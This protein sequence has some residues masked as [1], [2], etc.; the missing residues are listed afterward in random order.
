MAPLARPSTGIWMLCAGAVGAT[1][2]LFLVWRDSASTSVDAPTGSTREVESIRLA[3]ASSDAGMPPVGGRSAISVP[4]AQVSAGRDPLDSSASSDRRVPIRGRFVDAHG[5]VVAGVRIHDPSR[6]PLGAPLASSGADGEFSLSLESPIPSRLR[7]RDARLAPLELDPLPEPDPTG[8]IDLGDLRLEEGLALSVSVVDAAGAPIAAAE[9]QRVTEPAGIGEIVGPPSRRGEPWARTDALGRAQLDAL[10]RGPVL[11][12]VR[13]PD[14]TPTLFEGQ[15]NG[16]PWERSAVL[17]LDHRV[18]L[19][20]RIDGLP[21]EKA[22]NCVVRAWPTARISGDA[23]DTFLSPRPIPEAAATSP[24]AQGSFQFEGLP[25][26]GTAAYTVRGYSSTEPTLPLTDA[27]QSGHDGE[28]LVLR[29]LPTFELEIEVQDRASGRRIPTATVEVR[30]EWGRGSSSSLPRAAPGGLTRVEIPAV[31]DSARLTIW[32]RAPGYARSEAVRPTLARPGAQIVSLVPAAHLLVQVVEAGSLRPIAAAEV[33]GSFEGSPVLHARGLVETT[34]TTDIDGLARLSLDEPLRGK[35]RVLHPDHAPAGPIDVDFRDG[36][37]TEAV[38]IELSAGGQL[39]IRVQP[40]SGEAAAAADIWLRS[41]NPSADPSRRSGPRDLRRLRTDDDGHL[42]LD[43]L[44]PGEYRLSVAALPTP[45]DESEWTA[46]TVRAG[47]RSAC[48][49]AA[50]GRGCIEALIVL[51]QDVLRGATVSLWRAQDEDLEWTRNRSAMRRDGFVAETDHQGIQRFCGRPFG[52]YILEAWH[53]DLGAP[54]RR[55][56]DLRSANER[57]EWRIASARIE[58]RVVAPD[59]GSGVLAVVGIVPVDQLPFLLEQRLSMHERGRPLDAS[60]QAGLWRPALTQTDGTFALRIPAVGG[61]VLVGQSPEGLAFTALGELH[62]G[63]TPESRVVRLA[64]PAVLRIRTT[65]SE[66]ALGQLDLRV[67]GEVCG[68]W[69]GRSLRIELPKGAASCSLPHGDWSLSVT[70][71]VAFERS[72]LPA[73]LANTDLAK[74][75]RLDLDTLVISGLLRE[76]DL[77]PGEQRTM[78]LSVR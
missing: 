54:L 63:S 78:D 52:R 38:R 30:L 11:L 19:A 67:K 60:A 7:S 5:G 17:T 21:A 10:A 15:A 33:R 3:P 34:D 4:S 39:G 35:L 13:A 76:V 6:D 31:D 62:P 9:I 32:A 8:S 43:R 29:W 70:S 28:A 48:E 41:P 22:A 72:R 14:R 42:E 24:D 46:V 53:G 74:A 68:T 20:G 47:E 23:P 37:Q 58:G 59:T 56:V 49:L 51:D 69:F 2:L 55:E 77:G 65:D 75:P 1:L 73:D 26:L 25:S 71:A 16:P 61:L 36:S 57:V 27:V 64:A 50:P 18:V 12:L 40:P 45:P 44:P 66:W